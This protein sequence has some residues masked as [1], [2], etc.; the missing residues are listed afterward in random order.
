MINQ[1]RIRVAHYDITRLK[2]QY[3]ISCEY[4]KNVTRDGVSINP[5][6][7]GDSIYKAIDMDVS[8]KGNLLKRYL[9]RRSVKRAV[10]SLHKYHDIHISIMWDI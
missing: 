6:V 1:T 2:A 7:D 10:K 9:T 3:Y 5:L 4:I 8:Y